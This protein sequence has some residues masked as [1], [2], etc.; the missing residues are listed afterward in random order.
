MFVQLLSDFLRADHDLVFIIRKRTNGYNFNSCKL[1][2]SIFRCQIV[3]F[4]INEILW[5]F[6]SSQA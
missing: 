1:T 3:N 6:F 4:L 2:S 5:I